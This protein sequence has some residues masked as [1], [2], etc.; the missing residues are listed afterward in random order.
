MRGIRDDLKHSTPLSRPR[1]INIVC[2][3]I[4]MGK[5]KQQEGKNAEYGH[6]RRV[7]CSF[8]NRGK[9]IDGE[10]ETSLVLAANKHHPQL[11]HLQR[12]SQRHQEPLGFI[13]F[14]FT[15]VTRTY[16]IVQLS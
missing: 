7:V 8:T 2:V 1:A 5:K 9:A 11:D 15:P 6:V 10:V 13:C 16:N 14:N 4:A 12:R 3:L